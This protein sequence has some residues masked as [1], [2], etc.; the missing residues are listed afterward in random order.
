MFALSAT[1]S[2]LTV[3]QG[4]VVSIEG[5]ARGGFLG[6]PETLPVGSSRGG[7]LP[8]LCRSASAL[9]WTQPQLGPQAV[10]EPQLA[11]GSVLLCKAHEGLAA[12]EADAGGARMLRRAVSSRF[13]SVLLRDPAWAPAALGPSRQPQARPVFLRAEGVRSQWALHTHHVWASALAT[14]LAGGN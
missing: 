1:L 11:P 12:S 8:P 10:P 4:E 2:A 7:G 13:P 9:L 3:M 6:P 5:E 14:D